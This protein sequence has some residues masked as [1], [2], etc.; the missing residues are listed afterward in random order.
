MHRTVFWTRWERERV[1]RFGRM[2]LKQIRKIILNY[3]SGHNIKAGV[4]YKRQARLGRKGE[5]K[6]MG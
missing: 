1:G 2:A 5:E 3:P 6:A 4:S